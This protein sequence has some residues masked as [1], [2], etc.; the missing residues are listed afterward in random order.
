VNPNSF[1][2]SDEEE[3]DPSWLK[4]AKTVGICGATSTPLWLMEKVRDR[5]LSIEN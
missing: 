4:N 3:L 5:V 2:I 1:F